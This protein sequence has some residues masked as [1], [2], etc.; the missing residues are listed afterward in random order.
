M[1]YCC[2][3]ALL[4]LLTF[5]APTGLAQSS[6]QNSGAQSSAFNTNLAA[7]VFDRVWEAFDKDYAMFV[8]RPQVDWDKLREQY[9]PKALAAQ[10][11]RELAEVCADMLKP[12]RD[13][14]VWLTVA[15]RNVPVFNRPRAA[16]SNPAA[17]RRLLGDLKQ[18]GR[19]QWAITT[20]KIGFL[21][22][23]A[24]NN[25]RIPAQCDQVLEHMRDT[26]GLIIDVRLNGGGSENLAEDVAGRFLAT[27]FIYA[28]SQFRNGPK[29]TDL[30]EKLE[31]RAGPRG[32]WRYDRPVVLLI[33]QKCMSSNESFVAMMSGVPGIFIMGDHTCGSSGNPE[34]LKLPMDMTVSVPRWI[35]YLPDGTPLD[36]RGFQPQFKFEA[37]P[38]AFEAE[39][40][41]LLT[42]ALERLRQVP[43]P[44]QPIAGPKLPAEP[45][46]AQTSAQPVPP[47]VI[48]TIPSAGSTGVDPAITEVQ[49]T[50]SKPMADGS[51]SWST[52]GEDTFPQTT[53]RPHYLPDRCTCVLPV[54]L[55]PGKFYATWLNSENFHNFKDGAGQ[56]AVPYLLTFQTAGAAPNPAAANSTK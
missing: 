2:L 54:K 8:L 9:R 30:T 1:K 50:F 46:V 15:G 28:Y 44:A 36:E 20:H 33:G 32:P 14:H 13:L 56:S 52:W 22:I 27:D 23:Y 29:H 4:L 5:S 41:D 26:R 6:N 35:D 11:T 43:L 47:V 10:S 55:E 49:V 12:L 31:R 18:E 48:K 17:H 51:W 42:A 3:C 19:V 37:S 40:D 39:R 38:D 45:E 24:W 53:G 25:E 7:Q 16:N 34:I 21:A